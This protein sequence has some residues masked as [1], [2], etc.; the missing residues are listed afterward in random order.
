M[1]KIKLLALLAVVPMLASCGGKPSKPKFADVGKEVKFEKFTEDGE[2]AYMKMDFMKEK[3]LGSGILKGKSQVYI[4]TKGVAR[5]LEFSFI[6]K[7]S[8]QIEAKY[9][10]KNAIIQTS[11]KKEGG[12]AYD[13]VFAPGHIMEGSDSES[14]T[15]S[16]QFSKVDKKNSIVS[17]TKEAKEYS[18]EYEIKDLK[19]AQKHF[20]GEMKGR[21]LNVLAQFG[22]AISEYNSASEKEQKY[23]KFYE[24]GNIFTIEASIE[25]NESH[26]VDGKVDYVVNGKSEVK[27]QIDF[28]NGKFKS[29]AWG[30]IEST[31]EFKKD[32]E[33]NGQ[34]FKAGDKMVSDTKMASEE[35]FTA[36]DLTL[37]AFNLSDY[38]RIQ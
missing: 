16:L 34:S 23:Y 37:K 2:K 20:D 7:E 6:Q 33:Y 3:A 14:S 9:D 27:Y 31:I 28:T 8:E 5:G 32:T 4:S 15:V 19:E 12:A 1:K 22:D 18:V 17:A 21:L 35:S 26:K 11:T 30:S 36:K 25:E 13:N 10:Q 29:V 24:N 38:T